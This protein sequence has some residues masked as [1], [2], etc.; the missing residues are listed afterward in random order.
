MDTAS[1]TDADAE[2]LAV[3]PPPSDSEIVENGRCK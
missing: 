1:F 3:Q 2:V